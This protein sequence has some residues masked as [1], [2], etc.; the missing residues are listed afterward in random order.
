MSAHKEL[1]FVCGRPAKASQGRA[2]T[3]DGQ[4]PTV[5]RCCLLKVKEAGAEGYQPL[6]GPKLY[7]MPSEETK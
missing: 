4:R 6:G 3:D 5:G 2:V 1:C 7:Y